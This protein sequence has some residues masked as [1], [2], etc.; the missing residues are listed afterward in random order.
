MNE[1]PD[2]QGNAQIFF[3]NNTQ[4]YNTF[5]ADAFS[6]AACTI[7]YNV[8]AGLNVYYYKATTTVYSNGDPNGNTSNIYPVT[9]AAGTSAAVIG[10]VD[11][12][13]CATYLGSYTACST[14][15]ITIAGSI[16]YTPEY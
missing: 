10:S 7:P 11:V 16:G 4:T 5:E 15:T 12:N 1:R 9:I 14:T 8:P 3:F 6:D 13:G 2:P